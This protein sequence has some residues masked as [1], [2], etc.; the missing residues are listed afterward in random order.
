MQ[1]GSGSDGVHPETTDHS[2]AR[3]FLAVG[4][5]LLMLGLACTL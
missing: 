3:W 4:L 1:T 5:C 2:G